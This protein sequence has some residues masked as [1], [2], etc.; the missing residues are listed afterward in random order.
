MRSVRWQNDLTLLGGMLVIRGSDHSACHR[1][2][3]ATPPA[4][5]AM[6]PVLLI[7]TLVSASILVYEAALL[8]GGVFP[9]YGAPIIEFVQF[10]PGFWMSAAGA[11]LSL[12]GA[13][14]LLMV[15]RRDPMVA[16]ERAP[17]REKSEPRNRARPEAR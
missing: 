7:V 17:A 16:T 4:N 6:R 5:G 11:A 8:I 12:T 14:I 10:E 9:F 2:G 13:V 1:R 15:S 3:R